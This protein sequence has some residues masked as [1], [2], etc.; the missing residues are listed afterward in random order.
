MF[1]IHDSTYY[2]HV[3]FPNQ[4]NI[5]LRESR[6]YFHKVRKLVVIYNHTTL[7]A[8]DLIK[9]ENTVVKTLLN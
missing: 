5:T 9:S 3:N 8:P 4:S 6:V 1:G 7:Y 2:I